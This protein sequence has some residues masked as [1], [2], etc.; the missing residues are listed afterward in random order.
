MTP[1]PGAGLRPSRD[2]WLR[3]PESTS[4]RGAISLASCRPLH[5]RRLPLLVSLVLRKL[6]RVAA[7][8]V[9]HQENHRRNAGGLKCI[10]GRAMLGVAHRASREGPSRSSV[11]ALRADRVVPGD[12]KETNC[13]GVV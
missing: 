8:K 4:G 1:S 10:L 11:L 6:I 3:S 12:R 9:R 7:V 13:L 5:F 2:K